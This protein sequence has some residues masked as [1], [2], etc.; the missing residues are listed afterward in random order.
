[1]NKL[2]DFYIRNIYGVMGTL[3][4]HILVMLFLLIKI[5][6]DIKDNVNNSKELL[7]E[8]PDILPESSLIKEEQAEISEEITP[9][10][11]DNQN[12]TTNIASNR[13]AGSVS[14]TTNMVSNRLSD[15]NNF[16]NQEYVNEVE[17]ARQLISSVSNQLSQK[18][19]DVS[20][21]SMPVISTEGMNPESIKN[22]IY[23]GESTIEYY[24]DNRYHT[25]LYNPVYLAQGGGKVIVDIS[26]NRN[27]KVVRAIPRKTGSVQSE[28]LY[29]LAES[30]AL[31]T[32]F[33]ASPTASEIQT[34]TIHYTF[35]AQ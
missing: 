6:F 16:F 4:F 1:M 10:G 8:F 2:K 18:N 5:E 9:Q 34:G 31:Q 30:A 22:V 25:S 15:P 23:T 28:Q 12:R 7:I 3:V 17:A 35:I 13:L 27:G 32:V 21:I 29:I 26:V 19:I 14:G 24:L 11:S 33:N 20:E